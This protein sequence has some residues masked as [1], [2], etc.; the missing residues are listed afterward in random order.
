MLAFSASARAQLPLPVPLP[1]PLPGGGGPAAQPY[2]ANDGGGFRNILPPGENGFDNAAQ[3]A[4]FEATGTRP[5]H[6]SDQLDSA[7]VGTEGE[8]G[9]GGPVELAVE[10]AAYELQSPPHLAD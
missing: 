8:R 2:G 7:W 1:V 5:A 9:F 3:L 10:G 4:A 6:F